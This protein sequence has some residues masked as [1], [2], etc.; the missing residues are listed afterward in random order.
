MAQHGLISEDQARAAYDEKLTI[1]SRQVDLKA[2]HWVMY[3]RDQLEQQFG[4]RTLYGAGLKVYTT[5]DLDFNQRMQQ[6]LQSNRDVVQQQ[7]GDNAALIAV[8][9]RTGEILAFQGSLDLKNPAIAGQANARTSER[10]P[11]RSP[12][13]AITSASFPKGG[14]RGPRIADV[15]PCGRDQPGHQ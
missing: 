3:V 15:P 6:V 13:P 9:P 10:Q 4:D 14:G 1:K 5:L 12:K 7:G 8:D 11:G 2:P